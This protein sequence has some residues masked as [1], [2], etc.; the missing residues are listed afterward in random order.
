MRERRRPTTKFSELVYSLRSAPAARE[1]PAVLTS[2]DGS[3]TGAYASASDSVSEGHD[4]RVHRCSYWW[5]R[6]GFTDHT[7]FREHMQLHDECSDEEPVVDD[8]GF[9][10]S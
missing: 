2:G 4:A 9:P 10:K 5:C 7:E 8:M 3:V 1:I 6:D